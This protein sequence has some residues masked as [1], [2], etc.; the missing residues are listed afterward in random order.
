MKNINP[1]GTQSLSQKEQIRKAL[2]A[3][4]TLTPLD[5]L[6]RFGTMKLTTR[7]SELIDENFPI[8][9]EWVRTESGKKVMSYRMAT[10]LD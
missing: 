1:N 3:G 7:I 6:K 2:E 5:A 10:V 9:K 8:K 4:E